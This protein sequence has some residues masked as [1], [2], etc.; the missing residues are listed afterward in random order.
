MVP[1][2]TP[3]PDRSVTPSTE[4]SMTQLHTEALLPLVER[5]EAKLHTQQQE[6]DKLREENVQARIQA[7]V[8]AAQEPQDAVS[9]EQLAALQTRLESLHEAKLFSDDELF[10]LEDLCADFVE[11]QSTVGS[12]ASRQ[13]MTLGPVAELHKL[14]VLSEK[15]TGAAAFARQAKR[16]FV[17]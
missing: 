6:M 13:A 1:V 4:T 7:A 15:I 11:L 17:S 3:T 8:Q 10:V 12:L 9:D 5:L 16:K 2:A 14:V